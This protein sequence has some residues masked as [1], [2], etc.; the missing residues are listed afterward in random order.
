MNNAKKG[1]IYEREFINI[2]QKRGWILIMRATRFRRGKYPAIVEFGCFDIVLGSH[3]PYGNQRILVQCKTDKLLE[4]T[5]EKT[6]EW[7]KNLALK[8]E[9]IWFAVRKKIKHRVVFDVFD[10]NR[11][12]VERI[13]KTKDINTSAIQ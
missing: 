7:V 11:N 6:N 4:E 13:S 10:L 5:I 1:R 9:T 2:M 8:E 12:L 3:N